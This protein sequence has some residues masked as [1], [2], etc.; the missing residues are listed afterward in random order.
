MTPTH[1][2]L[3]NSQATH[4]YQDNIRTYFQCP[5]CYLVF[6]LP[7]AFLSAEQEKSRY[8]LHQNSPDDPD[9]REFLSRMA[10]PM[11]NKL[12]EKSCGL[13][14]GCGPGPT[15][16]VIFEEMGH[17]MALYD[18]YYFPDKSVLYRTYDF[19]TATEVVEHLRTPWHTLDR[20]WQLVKPG[21]YLGIMTKMAPNVEDFSRWHYKND[22]THICF[23]SKETFVWLSRQWQTAPEFVGKDVVIFHKEM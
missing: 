19:V 18:L 9:Y 15:L 11:A 16:S 12:S 23:Y 10:T 8:D 7:E 5:G 22:D 3:C 4:Y 20:I 13:D 6:V 1:C 14:F 17:L 2:P 21:G